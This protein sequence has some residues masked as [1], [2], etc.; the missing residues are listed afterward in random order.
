MIRNYNAL[1]NASKERKVFSA[2]VSPMQKTMTK[3]KL[4]VIFGFALT[5]LMMVSVTLNAQVS[6]LLNPTYG[7]TFTN[8]TT[9]Y[10]P[11]TGGT[12]YQS[13]TALNT[14]AVS[15]AIT[16]PFT[17]TYNN[18]KQTR[19]FISNN[20]FITFGIAP[21]ASTYTPISITTAGAAG[22]D[23]AIAGSGMNC[24]ASTAAGGSP[25]IRYGTNGSGDFVVQY[26][27]IGQSGFA[28]IRLTY[29][30]TLKADG[31]TI[32][33]VYGPNNV[34][35]A[36]AGQ[37]QVGLRG[38]GNQ[39]YNNRTLSSGGNWNTAGGAAGTA[40]TSA[41]SLTATTTLAASGRTFQWA[42]ASTYTPTYLTTP[43][44]TTQ[45]FTTW[46]NGSGPNNVPSVNWAT[47]GY[48]NA[49]WQIDN[50]TA[51]TTGSGWTGTSGAYSPVDFA[52][53][54]GG[55][56]ARF[57]SFNA[58]SPQVGYL[59]YYVDLSGGLGVLTL[60][61]YSINPSGVDILQVFLSTDGGVTFTQ[62]GSNIG[63][64]TT[65]TQRTISLGAVTSA[66]SVIRFKA[67]SDFGNDDIG[68]DNVKINQ[69]AVTPPNCATG[70]VPADLATG[71]ARNATLTWSAATGGP[72]SYDVYFGTSTNPPFVTNTTGLSYVPAPM[73]ATTTYFWKIVPK[74]ANGD[75]VGCVEQSF[76]T[77]ADFVYCASTYSSGPGTTDGVVNV[78]LNTLSNASGHNSTAPYYTFYNAVTVPDIQQGSSQTV[79]ITYGS[80]GS[81]FGAVWIDFNQN[82][83]FEAS[84]GFVSATNAGASGTSN[85][86]ITVPVGA[87]LGN[88]RMRVRG[89]NDSIL[90]TAQACG[91]SSSSFGETEDYIVNV[92]SAPTC[93]SPTG[94]A[95]SDITGNTADIAWVAPA[96][97]TPASY[98]WEIRTSGAGGSGSSGL[99][100]SGNE[101]APSVSVNDVSG[102]TGKTNYSLYVRTNCTG[103]DGSSSWAGPVN[104]SSLIDCSTAIALTSNTPETSGVLSAAGG[105]Y[106]INACGFSTPGN[107]ALY[108]YTAPVTGTYTLN[109]SSLNSGTGYIDYFF[110]DSAS[111]CGPTGWTCID[112]NNAIGADA[113]SLTGGV[114]YFI[115]L[116]AETA[117]GTTNHTF[118]IIPPSAPAC[119]SAP[120]APANGGTTCSASTTLSWAAVFSATSYDVYLDSVLVSD[121]QTGTTYSATVAD[122]P[123]TWSVVPSNAIGD[124]TGC[125]DFTFTKLPTPTGDTFANPIDLGVISAS[126]SVNGGNQTSNC[127]NNDY[128][129][130]STPGST[131]ARA[132]NDVF[133]KFEITECGSLMD[134]GTCT[135]SFDTY[136]QLLDATGARIN[137]DDDACSSPNPAGS[138]ITTL[139]LSP[140]IY[141]AVVEGFN[142]GDMGT[143]TL[144]F[145]YVAGTP[146]ITYYQDVDADGFGNPI[147]SQMACSQPVGYVTDNTDCND[148]QI[149]YADVDGDGFGSTTQVACGVT[150][151]TD[152]NDNQIQYFDGDGDN[153]GTAVQVACGVANTG[154]CNDAVAVINPGATEV[155]YD[156]IDN[157][158]NGTI[159][160][161]CTPIVTVVQGSQCGSTLST[162]DQYIYANIVSGAQGYRFRVTDMVTNQVQTID[163][164]LRVFQLTQLGSYAFNR[165]YQV[166]V[167]VRY[168]NVWQPFY[169][170][171]C[172]VTT[173]ATTT[174]VQLAQCG[175]TLTNMTDIIYAN[176]VPFAAGYKFRV[177]NL[178]TSAQQEI[179][180]PVRDIRISTT[181]I[182]EFNSTY[183]VE[184]AVKNTNG[185]YLP[186]GTPCNITTPSFPTSQLQLSQ[187]DVIIAN[188]STTIYADSYSGAS[189]YRFR[190]TNGSFTYAFDRPN[191]SFVL[192]TIPGLL[193]ATTYSV[194]VALEINGVFGPYG[195][196]CTITT[197][198]S[199][200]T[201]NVSDAS[202]QVVTYPNPFAE[203]FKLDVITASE[204]VINVKVYD[205]LGKLVENSNVEAFNVSEFEIGS[206]Y[207][208]GVY[209]VI[210]SQ[211]DQ[212]KTQRVIKR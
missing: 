116:D 157:N 128:T 143:Y 38:T 32:Q 109:I 100:A 35:V 147:V 22:Y 81:Q 91:A 184:V 211:G 150:N 136:V 178:L 117:S 15:A 145:T 203:S 182:A 172:T 110:K 75:A 186:Y 212:V 119:V 36:S 190:F 96:L 2:K 16:L 111:G 192:S 49:S 140:G 193:P 153:Y 176:N 179:E 114:T 39:D 70:L 37:G 34:G 47:N 19:V 202:L 85:I 10:T 64:S 58:N 125:A 167:S 1:D 199:A 138:F 12:V 60:D 170:L 89:G 197:P 20:G 188:N 51:S 86:S 200:R 61:F 105:V 29:Q 65:W 7:Y 165:T 78:T 187:C 31:K 13:G 204:E 201:V 99:A 169:G 152:C 48:G 146:Q 87:V 11:L 94:L 159:D 191:R 185:S 162:I 43:F 189:T 164:A 77:G 122:G 23:G 127:W 90:T 3:G 206:S 112:D 67:T 144:D 63:T 131:L 46:T 71:V 149:Q 101:V 205:M 171:P 124:A 50:T 8:T 66:T 106:S 209:N 45:D 123:H 14:D 139:A 74:N 130:S 26:Q 161:G 40:S 57:H 6:G 69:P 113:F 168:A 25:E 73:A 194:Q 107:E 135:S 195:K 141:Y 208:S 175:S 41:M 52:S 54:V 155:C 27:D 98:D 104:F 134:I 166:E 76:T 103:G 207:P 56:S 163:K 151:N 133:Y 42:P 21:L 137:G 120:T 18:L 62:V 17:F 181:S 24:V 132:G 177:T 115:L 108:S 180:R 129:T 83:T 82:G 72:T 55:R 93:L 173:P 97:G 95:A 28:A 9:T 210:V 33:I 53:A 84:E 198:G 79:A 142:A 148:N 158:C 92:I 80:D 88:T 174:Q 59:D 30:I 160:E 4:G 196:V 5:F 156:G 118:S 121:N 183:S 44:T 126:T 102:L 154:D 68:I